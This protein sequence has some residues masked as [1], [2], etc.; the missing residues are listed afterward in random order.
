[1]EGEQLAAAF[2]DVFWNMT[3][4]HIY[5]LEMTYGRAI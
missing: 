3:I 1:M 5:T 4:G 2:L